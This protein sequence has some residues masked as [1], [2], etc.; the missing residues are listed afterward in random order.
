MKR[1][2]LTFILFYS[3]VF[4]VYSLLFFLSPFEKSPTAWV[5]FGVTAFAIC[6]GCAINYYT[7]RKENIKSAVYGFPI[8]KLGFIYTC[9]QIAVGIILIF[10]SCFLEIPVWIPVLISVIILAVAAI[11]LIGASTAKDI[12]EK[13]E[14]QNRACV[15]QMRKLKSD[16]EYIA[17][18]CKDTELKVSANALAEKFRYSDPVSCSELV[19][20]ET[21][22]ST[23]LDFLAEMINIDKAA[24]AERID[25]ITLLLNDRNR[26][27]KALKH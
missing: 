15:Q 26:R 18:I 24:A 1:K 25:K 21:R 12:I 9:T 5:E 16:A 6:A 27:C 17:D 11:G 23:E 3:I 22:I 20:V 14:I 19:E 13:H 8:M 2:N 4:I 7:F 10:I